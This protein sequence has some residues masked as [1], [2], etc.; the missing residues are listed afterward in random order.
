MMKGD[1]FHCP[2]FIV[3]KPLILIL[4][5]ICGIAWLIKQ[6][7]ILYNF[8]SS[9]RKRGS[10]N[11]PISNPSSPTWSGISWPSYSLSNSNIR[12][13]TATSAALARGVSL[14]CASKLAIG[15]FWFT[16]YPRPD[17]GS[18]G[19]ITTHK[20]PSAALIRESVT[21]FTLFWFLGHSKYTLLLNQISNEV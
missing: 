1:D 7:V 13:P 10:F 8:T 19:H 6:S 3:D 9:L 18:F 17:W 2:F 4:L 16:Q 15:N 12:L 21:I 14:L 20:T 11:H 5:I